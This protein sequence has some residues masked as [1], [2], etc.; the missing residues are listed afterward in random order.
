MYQIA[1]ATTT[2]AMRTPPTRCGQVRADLIE[3]G[4]S[5]SSG[6]SC[7]NG[8]ETVSVADELD[9]TWPGGRAGG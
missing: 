7:G 6:G 5:G 3:F 2:A 4:A 8:R 9:A 1:L